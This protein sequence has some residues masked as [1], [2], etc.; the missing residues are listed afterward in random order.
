[1]LR[2]R[3]TLV[4]VQ[5]ARLLAVALDGYRLA[6]ISALG[7]N[8]AAAKHR[9]QGYDRSSRAR[10]PWSIGGGNFVHAGNDGIWQ[11]RAEVPRTRSEHN[12]FS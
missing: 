8:A 6:S 3:R 1:M 9:C 5:D 2:H 12:G 4:E 10:L 11:P 7:M